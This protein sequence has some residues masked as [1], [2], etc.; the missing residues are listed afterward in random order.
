MSRGLLH[1]LVLRV[2]DL[3]R[4]SAFYAAVLADW[5]YELTL[6][7]ETYQDWKRWDLDSPH[8]ITLVQGE[9]P[10]AAGGHLHHVAFAASSRDDVDRFHAEVL[11]PLQVRGLGSV[12]DPPC[13]CPEYEKGYYAVF[14]RDPDGLKLEYVWSPAHGADQANRGPSIPMG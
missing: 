3:R 1:H 4:S 12:E 9:R 6:G 2:V 14:F 11:V 5:N 10:P 13:D 8:R 7:E